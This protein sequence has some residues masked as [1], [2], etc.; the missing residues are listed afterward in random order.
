[1]NIVVAHG[2]SDAI[3]A[4]FRRAAPDAQVRVYDTH[5]LSEIPSDVLAQAEVLYSAGELPLPEAAPTLRW[6]QA[7]SAGVD[8]MIRHPLFLRAQQAG[9][10][11]SQPI[12]LTTAA[13]VHGPNISEYVLMMML[14]FAHRLHRAFDMMQRRAWSHDRVSF[15]PDELQGA[16]AA[17]IGY[18]GIGRQVAQRCLD[19]GMRV[20]VVRRSALRD[21]L[22]PSTAGAPVIQV[23]PPERLHDVL[24]VSDYVVL[25]VPLSPQTYHLIDRDA[26]ARMKPNA[27]LINIGRGDLVDESALI[28][29]LR[30][31][32]IAGAA[33][34][35]FHQ[36]PLPVDSPL[37]RLDNVILT[38]HIAGITPRYD[39]RAGALFAENLRR[40]VVGE[41][42]LNQVDFARGY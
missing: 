28:E 38:P 16:T 29:A 33:L 17:I 7:H 10:P 35:V 14:A 24:A 4:Q 6:V 23:M 5:D 11:T 25:A 30:M 15:L 26:I 20:L 18:G 19:F 2:F 21:P 37:W 40:Y 9:R 3:A 36:E 1:M 13:G 41:P 8:G 39:E 34:D 22:S 12:I 32:R 27:V 31:R 42:L